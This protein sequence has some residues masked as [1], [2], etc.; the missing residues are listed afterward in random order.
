MKTSQSVRNIL[1]TNYYKYM[2]F[3]SK[4]RN[5]M[6]G[7]LFVRYYRNKYRL[8]MKKYYRFLEGLGIIFQPIYFR[9][10]IQYIIEIIAKLPVLPPPAGGSLKLSDNVC[11]TP[12]SGGGDQEL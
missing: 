11:V 1:I 4:I 8:Y 7:G 10:F 6:I 2:L 12:A 5:R 3:F 9:S